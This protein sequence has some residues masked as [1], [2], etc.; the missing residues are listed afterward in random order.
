MRWI[1][2]TAALMLLAASPAQAQESGCMARHLREALRLNRERMP[3]YS[4]L[5]GGRSRAISRRLIWA[6]RLAMPAAWYVDWRARKFQRLGIPVVCADFE[7]MGR[8][9]AFR[10]RAD[11]PPPL[12]AFAPADPGRIAQAVERAFR[13]GGFAGAGAA[14]EG[15]IEVLSRVPGFHCM[16]RHLLESAL[17]IANGAQRYA[18]DAEARGVASPARLSRALLSMHLATLGEASRLD[19][20][21]APLQA[22]GIPIVCQDVPPIPPH[23]A[24][25]PGD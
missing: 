19:R 20:R 2:P 17:R 21:A 5:S 6:E 22:E 23:P 11:D 15:E 8:T 10:P 7:P 16:T 18:A 4:E 14:L 25:P 1:A 24:N 9:P 13:A 12:S 3:L